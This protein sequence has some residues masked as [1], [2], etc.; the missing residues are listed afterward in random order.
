MKLD[1]AHQELLEVVQHYFGVETVRWTYV[2][3]NGLNRL[4]RDAFLVLAH[5]L[6]G[7][8][9]PELEI[10]TGCDH[11][12]IVQRIDT[13]AA[14]DLV[15]H[16]EPIVQRINGHVPVLATAKRRWLEQWAKS[17]QTQLFEEVS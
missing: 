13:P 7:S 11:T 3:S 5:Q 17:R 4:A 15:P 9:A 2:R 12:M 6:M 14:E 10:R 16:L 1:R 8:A